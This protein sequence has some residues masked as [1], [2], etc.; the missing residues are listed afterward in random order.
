MTSYR[1]Q[2]WAG[3]G[4]TAETGTREEITDPS[5]PSKRRPSEKKATAIAVSLAV[6]VSIL[7]LSILFSDLSVL[8]QNTKNINRLTRKIDYLESSV[9]GLRTELDGKT[10]YLNPLSGDQGEPSVVQ[11]SVP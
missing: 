2:H 4:H 1:V 3:R 6:A 10:R 5:R 7:I 9:S 8:H 11:L